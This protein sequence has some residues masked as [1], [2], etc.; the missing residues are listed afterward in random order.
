MP[1]SA[2]KTTLPRSLYTV[3]LRAGVRPRGCSN[4]G[5]TPA[6]YRFGRRQLAGVL[7]GHAHP[8]GYGGLFPGLPLT[9]AFCAFSLVPYCCATGPQTATPTFSPA[10]AVYYTPTAVTIS[11]ATTGAVI[12]Y[13]TDGTNPTT[14]STVYSGP[15]T[16]TSPGH[17]RAAAVAP[18]GSLSGTAIAWYTIDLPG[19]APV[20]SL[21]AGAYIA[22][23][24]VALSDS[25]PNATIYYSTNGTY[26]THSSPIYSGPIT[27][28]SDTTLQAFASAYGFQ[29]SPGMK[30]V[31]TIAA[32]PAVISPPSGTYSAPQTVSLS[33][34]T[35]G[36]HFHYTTDGSTPTLSSASYAAP[37]TIS[38]SATVQAVAWATN[39]DPSAIASATYTF[40][41]PAAAP[42]FSPAAGTYVGAQTVSISDATLNAVVHYTTDGSTP[43][44]NS[45]LYSGP[46]P[47]TSTETVKAIVAAASNYAASGVASATYTLK[48]VPA[49]PVFSLA[50]GS[51]VGAQT[52]SIASS[53]VNA[54]VYY[55]TNGSTPTSKSSV[56]SA[57]LTVSASETISAL[58]V[59][60]GAPD[61][62]VTTASYS[63]VQPAAPVFSPA[64]GTYYASQT[65]AIA[66]STP[67]TAIY[68][69]TDGTTPTRQSTLYGVPVSVGASA[70]FE[71]VAIT[72][73][74]TVSAVTKAWYTM[75]IPTATPVISLAAGAYNSAQTATIGD[76]TPG[77]T[78]YYTTNGVYPNTSSP[79]YAGPFTISS[80][81]TV[82][83][84]ATAPNHSASAVT[85]ASY[86]IAAT[87]PAISPASGTY[88][89]VQTV[90]L[91]SP[92]PGVYF[93]YTLDG[94]VPTSSSPYYSGPFTVSANETVRAASFASDYATSAV[95]FAT[96][97]IILPTATPTMSPAAGTY[98][99]PQ[100]VSIVCANTAAV[101]YYTTNGAAP[102]SASSVYSGPIAVS[103]SETVSAIALAPGSSISPV[104]LAVYAITPPAAAPVFSL[105]DGTY[106]AAQTFTISDSTPGASIYYTTNGSNPTSQS[107]L[108]T[109]PITLSSESNLIAAALAP[110]GSL[111]PVAKA[112][113]DFVFPTSAPVISPPGGTYSAIPSVTLTDS[114]PGATIYY[115]TDGSYP[116]TSSPVYSGPVSA[117][118]GTQITAMA[119]ATGYSIGPG[120]MAVYTVIAPAPSIT[121]QS[122]TFQNKATVTITDAVPGATLYYT[123]DGSTPS[124][125]SAVY[126][127][128]ITVSPAQTS[129]EVYR[130]MAV[131]GGYL[132]SP[133]STATFIVDEPAGTLA[134]ATIGAT[135]LMP[136][137]ANFMGISTN[138]DQPPLMMGQAST[139]VN[140][141]YRT[142]LQG[143]TANA[144]APLLIRIPG[145][146]TQLS[147]IQ[148]GIEP[149]VELAQAVN[150]DYTLGVDLWNNTLPLAQS[151][152]SAWINGVPN[153]LIYAIE[154]GNEPDV[155]P[156]NGARPSTY[157]FNQYLAQFQQW[158]TGV[159]SVT[160]NA[161]Q[162]IGPS[163]GSD[164]WV[165]DAQP[166][167]T[168][169]TLT[170]NV[171][172]QHA[173]LGNIT[174][175]SGAAWPSDYL[176]YPG[177]ATQ[178]PTLFADYA[179]AAHQAGRLFRMDEIN[180]FYAGGVNGISTTFS[181]S[182]W[183]I[184]TMF[185]YLN[186]GFDGVNWITAQGTYYQLFQFHSTVNGGMNVFSVTQVAPLYYGLLVFSQ[187]AGNNAQLLPVT[188]TTN[189]NVSIW[190]TVD[191]TST[192]HVIVLNKD[193]SA[194]GSVQITLP[195]YTTGTIRYLLAADYSAT[196]GVT[197]GGQTFD[198]T[199]D[200][201]L[202]G[203]QTTTTITAPTGVFTIPNMPITS[204]AEID[205]SH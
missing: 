192:A 163:L 194:T 39:Y 116:T 89:S 144:T 31:Y 99:D 106:N 139:G 159:D 167:L 158:Q 108:Y 175:A 109:G 80:D 129:T 161:F 178:Y 156:T 59:A 140:Q 190:A 68:Y 7:S 61:S 74:G 35:P 8:R 33:S 146:D 70:N 180:S 98:I 24:T 172:S 40:A 123:S 85:S 135:P 138:Y 205:F 42:V 166:A 32:V 100:T 58:A 52:L 77:A 152:A 93:H 126:S 150:V 198:G 101:I 102:T 164:W 182:L 97:T 11:D 82:Q 69:T 12:Y 112:W 65:V 122:G 125:S 30:V 38:K 171:V 160:G 119:S 47:V 145:D 84:L 162:L 204:A 200:G 83:A 202:Q 86:T 189:A 148:A 51:Y 188:T 143:L 78:I 124:T 56:Y 91:S 128:P 155:Y 15:I 71:A 132:P 107:T 111:S 5:V 18:G 114:T 22:P 104:T 13:T 193:E 133:V 62:P 60:S 19:V 96:Y 201:T 184:D 131:A 28:T 136:V 6:T 115:T 16:L 170:P 92:T 113:Y 103:S 63:I 149:L 27:I 117:P 73:G 46:F 130:A 121:P 168:A 153:G 187:M 36:V 41:S 49:A 37:F 26:P 2:L 179:A 45:S 94:S 90:T 43:T 165:P 151:E 75:H 17:L 169:D 120:S 29:T 20:A 147:D 110:G 25:S 4:L 21:A 197:W 55:T 203:Q 14:Q 79:V 10:S 67:G 66:D 53:T 105:A 199:Q 34:P 191:D 72:S 186:D 185:N 88:T 177:S 134:E 173:Y 176:L 23:Q 127:G 54:V 181:S 174:Q 137:P 183:S 48:A 76:S 141:A 81:A 87:P 1:S 157:S 142:L 57:P 64:S 118:E 195:G 9:L 95:S 44:T 196:N 3:S 154:I 50:A